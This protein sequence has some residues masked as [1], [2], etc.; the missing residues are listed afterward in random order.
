MVGRTVARS[1]GAGLRRGRGMR[2]LR[3]EGCAITGLMAKPALRAAV[4]QAEAARPRG[5]RRAP[6]L[7]DGEHR[8]TMAPA[9]AVGDVASACSDSAALAEGRDASGWLKQIRRTVWN[10]TFGTGRQFGSSAG[11]HQR[12]A[13]SR[14]DEV[15]HRATQRRV[16][17]S[18]ICCLCLRWWS[19]GS[20]AAA[21]LAQLTP[22]FRPRIRNVSVCRSEGIVLFA[23]IVDIGKRRPSPFW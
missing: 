17:Q 10:Q 23:E 3:S 1:A 14:D 2:R 20:R 21:E 13:P 6:S 15:G 18:V 7:D 22:E 4:V 9:G 19:S 12:G 16:N 8:A 5:R 11:Q